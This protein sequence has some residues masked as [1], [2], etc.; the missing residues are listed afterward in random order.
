MKHQGLLYRNDDSEV[1]DGEVVDGN[2]E[3][4]VAGRFCY[5]YVAIFLCALHYS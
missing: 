3:V 5:G 4:V 2:S 1:G